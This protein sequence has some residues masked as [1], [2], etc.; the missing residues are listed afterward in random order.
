MIK[1]KLQCIVYSVFLIVLNSVQAERLKSTLSVEELKYLVPEIKAAEKRL[2]NIKIESEAWVEE[3]TDLSNPCEPWKRTPTYISSTAWFDGNRE[4]RARVDFHKKVLKWEK[5]AA[6]Y[7]ESN[8]SASFDGKHGRY[9]KNS[10]SHSGKVFHINNYSVLPD[11]PHELRNEWYQKMLGINASLNFHFSSEKE[12]FSSLFQYAIDPNSAL[13]NAG[14]DPNFAVK[15]TDLEITFQ[16]LKDAECINISL[17]GKR[18]QESWWLD[19]N[20]GFALLKYENTRTDKDGREVPDNST[21]VRRLDKV[22]ENLWW[23]MEVYFISASFEAGNPWKRIVYRAT[24]VVA[25]APNFADSIFTPPIP[26][27]YSVD[28][29]EYKTIYTGHKAKQ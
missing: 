24:N 4:G 23:P 25:N 28:K 16:E 9:I 6:P 14:V 7:L 15:K 8:Y 19:P 10:T 13:K 11:A 27:G 29:A 18:S 3:K 1:L 21:D 12:M 20:R 17:K 2:H 26:E 5:G 22:A